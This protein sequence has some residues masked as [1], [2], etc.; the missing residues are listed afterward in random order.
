MYTHEFYLNHISVQY[1]RLADNSDFSKAIELLVDEWGLPAPK[2]VISVTGGA[3][4]FRFD[5]KL[6]TSFTTGI[7]V[8]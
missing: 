1:I 8:G 7:V 5:S 3:S 6:K 2:I 4:R